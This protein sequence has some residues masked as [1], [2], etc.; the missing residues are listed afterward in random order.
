M[1][2]QGIIKNVKKYR[3]ELVREGFVSR[4]SDENKY[5]EDLDATQRMN[6]L[7]WMC[8]QILAFID[9][10]HRDHAIMWYGCLQFGLYC[11][12]EHSIEEMRADNVDGVST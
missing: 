8:D 5:A 2:E 6:H 7:V 1:T 4:K 12:N 10:G 9:Q 11:E 3:E